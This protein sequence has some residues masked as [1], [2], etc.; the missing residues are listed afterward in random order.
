MDYNDFENRVNEQ[1]SSTRTF[2]VSQAF[3]AL[4]RLLWPSVALWVMV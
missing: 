4:M 3:P 1:E 2:E